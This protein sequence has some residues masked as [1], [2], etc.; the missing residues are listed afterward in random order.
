MKITPDTAKLIYDRIVQELDGLEDLVVVSCIARGADAVFAQAVLDCGGPLEVVSPSR[1]YRK[2]RVKPDHAELFD[3][4]LASAASVHVMDFDDAGR[5]A[6][7]AANAQLLLGA[8]R[9]IAVWDGRS[10]NAV[11]PE[12]LSNSPAMQAFPSRSSGPEGAMR[13]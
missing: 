3:R 2:R 12:L 6:Y 11:A 5:D 1:N 13:Y 4:L 10:A 9:L 8:D 7:E